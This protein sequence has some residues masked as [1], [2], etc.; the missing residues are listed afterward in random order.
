MEEQEGQLQ[1]LEASCGGE[2]WRIETE[3]AQ[4]GTG[5]GRA[6]LGARQNKKSCGSD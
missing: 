3:D 5:S 4:S 2:A 1:D 6:R